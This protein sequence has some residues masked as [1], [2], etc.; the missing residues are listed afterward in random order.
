MFLSISSLIINRVDIHPSH[1]AMR[2]LF[3]SPRLLHLEYAQLLGQ[4][5]DGSPFA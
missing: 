4:S 3:R 2:D 5:T 1:D